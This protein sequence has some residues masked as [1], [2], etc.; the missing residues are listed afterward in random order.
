MGEMT[1]DFGEMGIAAGGLIKQYIQQDRY[2]PS[3]WDPSTTTVVNVQILTVPLFESVTGIAA[4][5]CTISAET[6][7]EHGFSF[8]D[9]PESAS[10]ISG[11]FD[12]IKS[13]AALK[14]LRELFLVHDGDIEHDPAGP[15][16]GFRTVSDIEDRMRTTYPLLR[17]IGKTSNPSAQSAL[18]QLQGAAS[19]AHAGGSSGKSTHWRCACGHFMEHQWWTCSQCGKMKTSSKN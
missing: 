10:T 17:Q 8:F 19:S 9:I 13:L 1:N 5:P 11:S 4:P 12:D 7:L 2:P 15:K 18:Y 3:S 14:T 16:I 6:Y